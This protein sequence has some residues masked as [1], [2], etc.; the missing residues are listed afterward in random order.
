M[1][2]EVTVMRDG[3]GVLPISPLE[4]VLSAAKNSSDCRQERHAG[5]DDGVR[6]LRMG[7]P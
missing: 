4:V 1:S 6:G 2:D 3:S 7:Q 5:S